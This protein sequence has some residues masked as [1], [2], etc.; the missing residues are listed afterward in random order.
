MCENCAL[1]RHV[2]TASSTNNCP[3]CASP[4]TD[5]GT[6]ST[7]AG[8]V[9][10]ALVHQNT[11]AE[12]WTEMQHNL[13]PSQP[14]QLHPSLNSQQYDITTSP[15]TQ[16]NASSLAL[17]KQHQDFTSSV[18]RTTINLVLSS[19]TQ[20]AVRQVFAANPSSPL[21]TTVH[22]SHPVIPPYDEA[23]T[24]VAQ[25]YTFDHSAPISSSLNHSCITTHPL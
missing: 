22:I 25:S 3:V 1:F 6:P 23:S 17:V 14:S 4:H 10:L 20:Q 15:T 16:Q 9:I 12:R 24:L 8:C 11:F 19:H 7:C 18:L 13:V 2:I 5:D 21:C